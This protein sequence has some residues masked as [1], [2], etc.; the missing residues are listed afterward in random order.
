MTPRILVTGG[1]GTLG[2]HVV[3]LLPPE[4]RVLTR[5]EH[6]DSEGVEYVT[7]DLLG[8]EGLD[9]ALAGIETVLHL[10]G[11]AKGDDA[12]ASN[13]VQ[14][15]ARADVR[16]LVVISVIGADTMPIAWFRTQL[17]VEQAVI[18]SGVP[19]TILRAAQ[20]H[21]LAL[22][23]VGVLAKMPVVPIPGGL[24][25]QPV[26]ARDVAE[27]LAELTL[28]EPAGRVP[29]IAGP[30]VYGIK[31]L[32]ESYLKAY[33]KHRLTMPVRIPGKIGK[34]YRAART[35]PSTARTWARAPGRPSW[36]STSD[37]GGSAL[38][39]EAL[40]GLDLGGQA[41]ADA[42]PDVGLEHQAHPG[43]A[44]LHDLDRLPYDLHDLVPL[45]LDGG[46]HGVRTVGQPAVPDHA[47]RLGDQFPDSLPDPE[48]R[49]RKGDQHGE[50]P[51][52]CR[53]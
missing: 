27:R 2:R 49:D 19:W 9:A 20:F 32:V 34:A 39:E 5:H 13:L 18:D 28:G 8:G 31:D 40:D 10:A 41:V 26:D 12:A 48:R 51:A 22:K 36:P 21:D 7:G 46:E 52:T 4:V 6:E 29:D 16:H 43:G 45:A 35:S 11:A 47:Y 44:G 33:G 30:S 37:Q 15:A 42:G 38:G 23:T 17:A 1:T 53:P 14:A 3:P 50:L 25:F 24:R